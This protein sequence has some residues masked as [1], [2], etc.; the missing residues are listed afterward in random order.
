MRMTDI[1]SRMSV[2]AKAATLASEDS[3]GWSRLV[4]GSSGLKKQRCFSIQDRA[5]NISKYHQLSLNITKVKIFGDW[6]GCFSNHFKGI[7]SISNQSKSSSV[8]VNRNQAGANRTKPDQNKNVRSILGRTDRH[9]TQI[10][11]SRS[12][13]PNRVHFNICV[14][15][16]FNQWLKTGCQKPRIRTLHTPRLCICSALRWSLDSRHDTQDLWKKVRLLRE[17]VCTSV[18]LV[19]LTCKLPF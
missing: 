16:V 2:R 15:S 11:H 4:A 8:T 19:P 7:Q 18:T 10:S 1:E 17:F 6:P 5:G 3:C 9:V 13:A 12:F 14:S